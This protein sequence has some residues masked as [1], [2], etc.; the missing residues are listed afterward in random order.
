MEEFAKYQNALASKA[1]DPRLT[2]GRQ[3]QIDEDLPLFAD[4]WSFN[5]YYQDEYAILFS[6]SFRN[7]DRKT[8]VWP[9]AENPL[10]RNR[11]THTLE[12]TAIAALIARVLGLNVPLTRAIAL[13]HD[14]GHA[15]FGHL[16]EQTIAN[17][18]GSKF[19]HEI[20]GP[21]VIQK[22]ERQGHGLNLSFEVLEGITKHSR[23][24]GQ[25]TAEEGFPLEYAVVMYSDKLAYLFSDINDCVRQKYIELSQLPPDLQSL[26]TNQRAQLTS[27][28]K[29]LFEES[30]ASGRVSFVDSITAKIFEEGRQW[31]YK[32]VYHRLDQE[33]DRLCYGKDIERAHAFLCQYFGLKSV[34]AAVVL[35]T[36]TDPELLALAKLERA[37]TVGDIKNLNQFGFLERLP[38]CLGVGFQE[39]DIDFSWTNK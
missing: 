28:L 15:P 39:K 23:G 1:F 34:D 37:E 18:V 20:F 8:Q 7:L 35:A 5:T 31:M 24:D 11:L 26:G 32:N 6:K 36:M 14:L 17:I 33:P 9:I 13:A 30:A 4:L 12:V 19:R 21:I 25:L 27:C 10:V 29:A 38:Y 3:F 22:I 16:F 2:R